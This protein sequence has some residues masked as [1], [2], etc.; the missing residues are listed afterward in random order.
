MSDYFCDGPGACIGTCP[1]GA[2]TVIEREAG[3]YDEA[4]VMERIIPQ[5]AAVIAAHLEHL[6]GHGKNEL[7]S[8]AVE[9]LKGHKVPVPA[10]QTQGSSPGCE[11][12]GNT[13]FSYA[14]GLLQGPYPER[15]LAGTTIRP[16]K[17]YHR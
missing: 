8:Q 7:H 17:P 15:F 10:H 11:S 5:G 2:I 1:E 12:W 9:Y 14:P 6:L 3:V 4:A 16:G 13:S